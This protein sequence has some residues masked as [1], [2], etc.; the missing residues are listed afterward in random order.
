MKTPE[1]RTV[2]RGTASSRLVTD[3]AVGAR[4]RQTDKIAIAANTELDAVRLDWSDAAAKRLIGVFD[5]MLGLEPFRP[6]PMLPCT[7]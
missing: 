1:F 2:L 7:R 6:N 5:V 3:P 4:K